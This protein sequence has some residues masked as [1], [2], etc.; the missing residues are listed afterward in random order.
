M[1]HTRLARLAINGE[2]F[3]FDPQTGES[4]TANPTGLV[5]LR[6]LVDN[7]QE[8]DVVQELV[9]RFEVTLE[10]ARSD[11]RDFLEHLRSFRLV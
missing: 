4:F 1:N 9:D 3:V 2:G 7:T 8:A 10:E 11:V 6:K 5:I